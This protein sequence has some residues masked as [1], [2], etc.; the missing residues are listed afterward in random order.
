MYKFFLKLIQKYKLYVKFLI[1]G[2]TST[3]V[4]LIFLYIFTDILKIYYLTSAVL[5]YILAFFISFYLQK[6]WT[7]RD[8][9]KEKIYQQLG[10]YLSVNL[11]NLG[12]NTYG[13]FILVS[14]LDLNY[15]LAQI[16]MGGFIAIISFTCY[17]F[18]I[19]KKV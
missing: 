6:F 19:F 14:K 11:L 3:V 8:N 5:A 18:I 13:M 1:S 10:L 9:G 12:I 15:I 17:R 4:D 16:I 2:G 7:F